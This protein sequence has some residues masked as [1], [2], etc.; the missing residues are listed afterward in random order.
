MKTL[1][2]LLVVLVVAL[3]GCSSP[4]GDKLS[5]AQVQSINRGVPASWVLEEYPFGKATRTP[6]GRVQSISYDVSDPRGSSQTL[7]L[8]F[9][10]N[11]VMSRKVYSGPIVRPGGS[12]SKP[13][14]Q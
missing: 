10:C 13:A 4:F 11:E 7:R 1:G 14:N 2:P 5:Y 3:A 8:E 12:H 6:D 9:D